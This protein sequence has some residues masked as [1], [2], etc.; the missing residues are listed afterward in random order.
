MESLNNFFTR[1]MNW[2][3]KGKSVTW[4]RSKILNINMQQV[5]FGGILNT[6]VVLRRPAGIYAVA[7][8]FTSD[9]YIVFFFFFWQ[10]QIYGGA[11]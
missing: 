8:Q 4:F 5:T 10:L 7:P 6:C 9:I 1:P 3:Q 11:L 2:S